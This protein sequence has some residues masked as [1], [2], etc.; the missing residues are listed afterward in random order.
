MTRL[1][2]M[3]KG[4]DDEGN[5]KEGRNP[6]TIDLAIGSMALSPRGI[7]VLSGWRDGTRL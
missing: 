3:E 2:K 4:V 1:P 7:E 5:G 6:R